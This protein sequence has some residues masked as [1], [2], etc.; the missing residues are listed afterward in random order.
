MSAVD[1]VPY[2]NGNAAAP[3]LPVSGRADKHTW[4]QWQTWLQDQR[5]YDGRVDGIPGSM[6]YRAIQRWTGTPQTGKLDVVTRK[7][8]QK[9]IGVTADGIW[10]RETWMTI[11]RKL[12]EGS[13]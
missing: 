7:A 2:L 4:K 11:Q 9:R 5:F 8:V 13:L 1:P 6:T 10:G 12:N 3:V